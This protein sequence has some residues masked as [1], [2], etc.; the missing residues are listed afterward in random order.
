MNEKRKQWNK[1]W[2]FLST[3]C[4]IQIATN[5]DNVKKRGKY[6]FPIYL[7]SAMEETDIE[8][9]DLSVRSGNCLRRAGYHTIGD[10]V[11][12]IESDEDLKNIR[13]CGKT[14]VAEI[15][16]SLLCYQYDVLSSERR[17]KYI[18]RINELNG[19]NML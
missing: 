9:L 6:K 2:R 10:L 15:M 18:E 16:K 5:M 12:A 1:E 11:N 4:E 17:K 13:N 3:Y 19:E 8:N 7:N 14:S